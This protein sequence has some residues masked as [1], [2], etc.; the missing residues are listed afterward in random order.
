MSVSLDCGESR[1]S[2]RSAYLVG[3]LRMISDIWPASALAVS[4]ASRNCSSVVGQDGTGDVEL[5]L[6]VK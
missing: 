5:G 1:P 4:I 3:V 6:P 2:F